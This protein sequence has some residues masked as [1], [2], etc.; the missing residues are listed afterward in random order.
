MRQWYQPHLEQR[1]DDAIVRAGD[2][3]Q[4]ARIA[5]T[6]PSR[7]R[8]LTDLT[9]DPPEAASGKAGI[10]RRDEDYLILSTIHSAKGQEWKAV[11]VLNAVDGCIPSDMATGSPEE[12]E[13]ERRL[14]YVAMT[15]ARDR[16]MLVLPQRFYPHQQAKRGDRHVY[17]ARSRFIPSGILAHF[18]N[19]AWP[20]AGQVAFP[21]KAGA[22]AVDLA[23][24]LRGRWQRTGT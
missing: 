7:A 14:L 2:L 9:L 22:P 8:F 18:E 19:A 21:G 3:D 23:A 11:F 13:E 20:A 24:R 1:F 10:P 12:I 15:R 4:L 16:L 6:Y 17:A 5:T